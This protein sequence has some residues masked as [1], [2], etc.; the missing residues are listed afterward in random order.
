MPTVSELMS[1]NNTNAMMNYRL[2]GDLVYVVT[3]Y[4]IF[5][6]GTDVTN[7]LQALVNL[8]NSQGRTAIFFP[9]GEYFVTYIN[10]DENIYYFGDNASFIGGYSRTIEQFGAPSKSGFTVD[11]KDF[12][13]K[14]DGVTDDALAIQA[15]ISSAAALSA[16]PS[17]VI[18][19]KGIYKIGSTIK[20]PSGVSV[21]GF[22]RNATEVRT[23]SNAV[24]AFQ[25]DIADRTAVD[26]E[27]SG[28]SSGQYFVEIKDMII[29]GASIGIHLREGWFSNL[30]NLWIKNCLI[31]IK[32][33]IGTSNVTGV[34]WTTTRHVWI[35]DGTTSIEITDFSNLNIW[36]NC[37]FEGVTGAKIYEPTTPLGLGM[38]NNVFRN[39]E[40]TAFNAVENTAKTINFK[41]DECYFEQDGFSYRSTSP[42]SKSTTFDSCLF[43]SNAKKDHTI[44]F[45]GY[46]IK[47]IIE[48]SW[49]YNTK[50]PAVSG[51]LY[52]I[53]VGGVNANNVVSGNNLFEGSGMKTYYPEVFALGKWSTED[54]LDITSVHLNK[55]SMTNPVAN[56]V[57]SETS[58]KY[59]EANTNAGSKVNLMS[60]D[61][62]VGSSIY[63]SCYVEISGNAEDLTHL[64][65]GV[66]F[67][68]KLLINSQ[69][70]VINTAE[71]QKVLSADSTVA[72][73]YE[74]STTGV[75]STFNISFTGSNIRY[76]CIN[77]RF[78][79]QGFYVRNVNLM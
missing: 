64:G 72:I 57:F 25:T 60:V 67:H 36:E 24:V 65:K 26:G 34:Y 42:N 17:I 8:A 53:N 4:D 9:S 43:A 61:Y 20:V 74:L 10:N 2:W 46:D 76:L 56:K 47:P 7:K 77:R 33:G 52:N 71:I 30:E 51:D 1:Q 75:T 28:N 27:L 68:L 49:F 35:K 23:S 48:N 11:V 78:E 19:P 70:G 58:T 31:G 22:G 59:V 45:D 50:D 15:A 6:D 44:W 41:F 55:V 21:Q 37:R 69:N 39:V 38:Q 32:Y 63:G 3:A 62:L 13:A 79:I 12:G 54:M 14:G 73:N 66:S 40:F 16:T 5:P 29:S 18:I